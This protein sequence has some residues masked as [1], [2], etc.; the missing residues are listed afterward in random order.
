MNNRPVVVVGGGL[1]GS[2]AAWQL[3]RRGVPVLLLEQ[4]EPGH[5]RGASHGSSRIFRHA[6]PNLHYIE[7]ARRALIGWREL[8]ESDGSALLTLTGAVDHGDPARLRV[9]ADAL[10]SQ[11]VPHQL[12]EPIEAQ[13]RWPGLRFDT[14][15]LHHQAAG[16]LHADRAV[17]ALQ[18]Q[19]EAAGAEIRHRSPVHTVAAT[20]TGVDLLTD[21]G[22]ITADQVVVA[23][24]AWS[25]RLLTGPLT[26]PPIRTTEEQ[27]AH[28]AARSAEWDWPS[29]IHH[30]GAG[31]RGH[32]VYGLASD[33]GIKVGEHGTGAPVDPDQ[34]DSRTDP[35]ARRRLTDYVETWLPG[36]DPS[37]ASGIN[38]LYSTTP[39]QHFLIDRSDRVTVAAGFSGHGF[40]FGPAVGDLIA[41]LVTGVGAASP[42]FSL[43]RF[44]Q[45]PGVHSTRMVGL[46]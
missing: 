36:V 10:T 33:D 30:P 21:D 39:D 4:F 23:A 43:G 35:V 7:L 25:S 32:Q 28:F 15:V 38:C 20:A 44:H 18:R 45:T 22:I 24:G 14:A 19:A 40:K 37:T 6:Y 41:D 16:R 42:L 17:A 34:R 46:D 31:H 9:L 5:S 1:A 3:A 2:S 26:L 13:Q 11:R 29:F 12:L 27:P 8:E